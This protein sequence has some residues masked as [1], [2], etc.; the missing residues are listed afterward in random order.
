MTD[1]LVQ[2]P[3]QEQLEPICKFWER[4]RAWW[5]A[6]G[7]ETSPEQPPPPERRQEIANWQ[8]QFDGINNQGTT[9]IAG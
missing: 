7:W 3:Y 6:R 4:R 5:R 8:G 9:A 1:R 2:L